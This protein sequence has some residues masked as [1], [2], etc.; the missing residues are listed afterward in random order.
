MYGKTF[1][2][3]IPQGCVT[4]LL[5]VMMRTDKGILLPENLL[6]GLRQ[7]NVLIPAIDVVE[8]TCTD[9][10]TDGN[11][12]VSEVREGGFPGNRIHRARH[13]HAIT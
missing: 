6:A 3:K 9:A 1:P 8:H 7:N 2:N 13:H 5:P 12:I 11:K 10:M 4:H